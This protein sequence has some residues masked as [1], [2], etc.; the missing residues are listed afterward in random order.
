M[1]TINFHPDSDRPD[2]VTA[3]EE[4]QQLWEAE[5]K[6]IVG[7]IEETT[8][9]RFA[10]RVINA[11]AFEGISHSQPLSLRASYPPDVKKATLVHE[12]CHRLLTGN[13]IGFRGKLGSYEWNLESHKAINL[14]LFDVWA[15]LYGEVFAAHQVETESMRQPFYREAWEWA[16]S[17]GRDERAKLFQEIVEKV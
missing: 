2:F 15:D 3:A 5:G 9:L 8:G 13:N 1:L 16:L 14:F 17:L 11:I 10:E 7:R 6:R 4:Y 12:L